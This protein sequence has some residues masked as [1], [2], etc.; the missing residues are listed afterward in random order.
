[1]IF[2]NPEAIPSNI[3]KTTRWY[4]TEIGYI[5]STGTAAKFKNAIWTFIATI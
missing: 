5:K 3:L 4:S 1:M 2:Y